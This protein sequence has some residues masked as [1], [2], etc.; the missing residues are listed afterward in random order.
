MQPILI[1]LDGTIVDVRARHYDVYSRTMTEMGREPL[2][3]A[4]YWRGRRS[5]KSTQDLLVSFSAPERAR[6]S[7]LWVGRVESPQA[8]GL[9]TLFPGAVAALSELSGRHDLVLVTLRRDRAGLADQLERLG[10]GHLFARVLASGPGPVARKDNLVGI[11]DLSAGGYVVGDT[12][13]D[14]DLAKK[15]GR[16]LVCVANGVRTRLFLT[17]QGASVVVPSLRELPAAITEA[18]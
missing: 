8:L 12:E 15:T 6:F 11:G 14:I 16:R 4:R 18:A 17:R 3:A 5:G 9:D 1:D 2:G 13:A 7:R 10:I